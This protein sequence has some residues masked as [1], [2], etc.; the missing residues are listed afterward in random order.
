MTKLQKRNPPAYPSIDTN[1]S[2]SL[3]SGTP[4][5]S[6]PRSS[7]VPLMSPALNNNFEP[8]TTTP[9]QNILS[10]ES[11]STSHKAPDATRRV[12]STSDIIDPPVSPI[13]D[14][15]AQHRASMP[16]H[17]NHAPEAVRQLADSSKSNDLRK[18]DGKP[19]PVPEATTQSKP[20]KVARDMYDGA[21]PPQYRR[22]ST[23]VAG[24]AVQRNS[25][26]SLHTHAGHSCTKCGKRRDSTASQA[27]S[28]SQCRQCGKRKSLPPQ[29]GPERPPSAH[30]RTVPEGARPREPTLPNIQ[31]NVAPLSSSNTPHRRSCGKCG[32][33]KRPASMISGP[34][35]SHSQ[36]G[37]SSRH[38]VNKI[39]LAIPHP[40][41]L[42]SPTQ[43]SGFNVNIEPPTA[44]TYRASTI[45]WSPST[46]ET[47]LFGNA[48]RM[49][50]QPAR[51]P[52][53]LNRLSRSLSSRKDKHASAP[54]PSQQL[55][56]LGE[57]N[58]GR[59]ISMISNAI[60]ESDNRGNDAKYTRL[61][62]GNRINRP[63]SP[64]SFIDKTNE[65][66]AFEMTDMRISKT[67]QAFEAADLKAALDKAEK[68]NASPTVYTPIALDDPMASEA[69]G[70]SK[71]ISS[72]ALLNVPSEK[73]DK[74]SRPPVTRF[75]SLRNGMSRSSSSYQGNNLSRG[76]SL[77]RL[78]S[79]RSA[80]RHWYRDD[81]SHLEGSESIAAY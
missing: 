37:P 55:Q 42:Q 64:F 69:D 81:V 23:G 13:V 8:A 21:H 61:G 45:P 63:G 62:V 10:R 33:H 2:G 70:R 73:D 75:R 56:N 1:V 34:P 11:V 72:G 15:R 28:N 22:Q 71:L 44:T 7:H 58:T 30:V 41:A 35:Q 9:V 53:L 77:K 18:L 74:M 50:A 3:E 39:G 54:L 40:P 60:G 46:D 49:E 31:T 19:Y 26:Q 48:T 27:A 68:H 4:Y 14:E 51:R 57:Q 16:A 52:S 80:H 32:K 66:D 78:D 76:S 65:D 36:P 5:E 6:L 43:Q 24:G 12:V 20:V 59:L 29:M 47:P 38:S 79:V 17:R 67:S 25:A